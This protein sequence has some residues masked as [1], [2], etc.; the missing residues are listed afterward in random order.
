MY[1]QLA[2]PRIT[3]SE[4]S[5][6][7]LSG[8]CEGLESTAADDSQSSGSVTSL[9]PTTQAVETPVQAEH[10]LYRDES[11]FSLK[12]QPSWESMQSR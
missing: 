3:D 6:H 10:L 12:V 8:I 7:R 2:D 11:A 1:N 9:M 5:G 4:T